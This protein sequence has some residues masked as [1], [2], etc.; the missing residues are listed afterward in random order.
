MLLLTSIGGQPFVNY[1]QLIREHAAGKVRY[2]VTDAVCTQ[3]VAT[4]PS[5]SKAMLAVRSHARDVTTLTGL[6]ASDSWRVY[7]LGPTPTNR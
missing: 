4:H 1:Q 7:D 6:P 2:V 5:C 3:V